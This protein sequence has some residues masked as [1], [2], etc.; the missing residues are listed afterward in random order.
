MDSIGY[1]I[2]YFVLYS[3]IGWLWET[4]YCSIDERK[5]IYRGFLSGPYCPIYG[6]GVV[7]LLEVLSPVK[8]NVAAL[9]V[10]SLV[11]M[12]IFEYIVSLVLEKVFHQRWW[13]YSGEKFNIRGRISLK[14]SLF[15]A[16]MSLV[17]VYVLQPFVQSLVSRATDVVIAI[18]I[19][20]A[21]IMLADAIYTV[22]RL[23]K[24]SQL[25][26]QFRDFIDDNPDVLF[27]R[28]HDNIANFRKSGRLRFTERRLLRAFPRAKDNRLSNY[29]KIRQSLLSLSVRS[30]K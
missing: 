18:S 24:F 4:V 3:L 14:S 19:S 7:I 11:V 20:V 2:T 8:G 6:F 29:E 23:A 12:S 22:A 5:F 28:I 16:A 1:I 17:I 26:G 30:Q 21:A 9:F 15:W 10:L 27:Q 25:L 13:D